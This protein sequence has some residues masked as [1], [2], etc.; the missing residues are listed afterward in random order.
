[1]NIGFDAK[2]AFFNRS[3]LGNYSRNLIRALETC[4]P[5]HRYF[6]YTSTAEISLFDHFSS[7]VVTPK[8]MDAYFPSHWRNRHLSPDITAHQLDIFHGLSNQLPADI[9]KSHVKSV[10]TF[11]DVIF[12]RHPEWY[13]WHDRMVYKRKTDFAVRKADAIIA[14]SRQTKDDL[15]RFF[16]ADENKISVIYQPCDP[17]FTKPYTEEQKETVRKKWSL[18]AH[19][20]L[21]VGNI[22]K[23]KNIMHV[24]QALQRKRLDIPL[25]IVGKQNQYAEELKRYV[26]ENHIPDVF[27]LHDISREELPLIYL[28]A[29]IFI[30]PSF[31]EGFGIP[32]LEAI[33]T[34]VPV[35]AGDNSCLKE[36]GGDAALYIDP[37]NI[38][39]IAETIEILWNDQ[40]IRES[41]REKARIQAQLFNMENYAA[42]MIR[43]YEDLLSH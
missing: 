30:Y 11:H 17:L 3:G 14:I 12:M 16:N 26:N 33:S 36:T 21:M 28:S 20:L 32:V 29:D 9:E 22:E 37:G 42:R 34:S 25:V 27:F 23:R 4:F 18:P 39:Q 5:D 6:L 38:D 35:I 40:H 1:M 13:K 8:G 15:I 10:V 31:F 19:F 7:E 24:L 2:R 41:L 43:L